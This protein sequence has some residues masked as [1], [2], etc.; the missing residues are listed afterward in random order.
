V[1]DL[2][3]RLE[4]ANLTPNIPGAERELLSYLAL[5]RAGA[6]RQTLVAD[7]SRI[8]SRLK[9]ADELEEPTRAFNSQLSRTKRLLNKAAVD[10]ARAVFG[11]HAEALVTAGT[12]GGSEF[13]EEGSEGWPAEAG[14]EAEL[15]PS[16]PGSNLLLSDTS[17]EGR[18][19]RAKPV[20][21]FLV[22]KAQTLALD[23]T[24]V[25]V[26]VWEIERLF[27]E[28][29]YLSDQGDYTGAIERLDHAYRLVQVTALTH[30]NGS[31]DNRMQVLGE[32]SSTYDWVY[33]DLNLIQENVVKKWYELNRLLGDYYAHLAGE[34]TSERAEFLDKATEHYSQ[35]LATRP[36]WAE[37]ALALMQVCHTRNDL[38]TLESAYEI[39]RRSC[40][41]GQVEADVT[42]FYQ[43]AMGSAQAEWRE[44][45]QRFRESR[46]KVSG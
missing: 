44:A 7:L 17:L 28:Y 14:E 40:E 34:T 10:Y 24:K 30:N 43:K 46:V 31:V 25:W 8:E 12:R 37:A 22:Q 9:R 15:A 32:V 29:N 16:S 11:K 42:R 38:P 2:V 27:R 33:Q 19:R 36:D 20:F 4:C 35:A 41:D 13:Y 3:Y 45:E 6:R 39:H 5:N 1:Y 26:D 21:D 23:E 18:K